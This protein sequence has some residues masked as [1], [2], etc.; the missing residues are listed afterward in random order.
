VSSL[1]SKAKTTEEVTQSYDLVPVNQ[2]WVPLEIAN[3]ALTQ[4]HCE[5]VLLKKEINQILDEY[6]TYY[7][8][9]D[10]IKAVRKALK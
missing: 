8:L 6:M 9:K 7:E 5:L 10:F 4:K 3:L 2:K 1:E